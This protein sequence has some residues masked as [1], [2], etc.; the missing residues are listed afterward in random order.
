MIDEIRKAIRADGRASGYKIV[1]TS[2]HRVEWY[3]VKAALDTAR[4]IDKRL[5]AVSV[6][7]DGEAGATRGA[8]TVTLHPGSTPDEIREAVSRAAAAAEGMKNPWYPLPS[9]GE[10]AAAPRPPAFAGAPVED[11][12]EGLRAA[13]YA[14]D[15]AHGA[16]VN[17]LELFLSRV[18]ERIVNSNGVDVARSSYRGYSEFIVNASRPGREEIELFG[19]VEFSE[20]DPD[21]LSAAVERRLSEAADRL[22][23]QPTPARAG[24]PVLFK[25]DLAANLYGYW[26]E[27]A[28]ASA[29]FQKTA[30]FATGDS[31][32]D[33]ADGG[34]AISLRAVPAI[35]GAV[36][37]SPYDE[38]GLALE[39]VACIVGNRLERLVGPLKYTHYL[40]KPATGAFSLFELAAGSESAD[41]LAREPHLEATAFSDFFV[42]ETTGDFAGEL[43]L[44]YLVEGGK[45][46]PVSGGSVSG[47]LVDNRGRVR[48]SRELEATASCL[49]PLACLVPR[50]TISPAG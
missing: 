10:A 4:A 21:R 33:P 5:Y 45:R 25:R 44:G 14:R 34:S 23:A 39:P 32:G 13:L 27:A 7:A 11:A 41:E 50:A 37:S 46:T 9:P 29:A 8:Y 3:F 22:V 17:S 30:P 43:R 19:D 38:D 16:S 42:D 49:A 24:L 40:G 20:P 35:P 18:D 6:Y 47:S 28:Q 26:F 36:R 12:M 1:E 48:L 2:T 15:G 31:V